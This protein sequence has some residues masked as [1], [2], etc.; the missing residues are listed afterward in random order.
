MMTPVRT[1]ACLRYAILL[2]LI[3]GAACD[4]P[5]EPKTRNSGFDI[6]VR[7]FEPLTP[8]QTAAFQ[9]AAARWQSVITGDLPDVNITTGTGVTA[10]RCN[11]RHPAF[12]GLIDDLLIFVDVDSIDG[13]NAQVGAGGPCF[14]RNGSRL[15][16]IGVMK[17]DRADMQIMQANGTLQNVILHEMGHVLGFSPDAW[18]ELGLVADPDSDDPIFTGANARNRFVLAGGTSPSGVPLENT[19]GAGTRGAHW[20]ETVFGAELMTGFISTG[21]TPLSAITLGSL[22]DIGYEVDYGAADTYSIPGMAALRVDEP[23]MRINEQIIRPIG[24]IAP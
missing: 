1:R 22:A 16:V 13:P 18:S 15:T 12:T 8:L 9:A 17:F 24:G 23:A 3:A 10:N 14:F 2:V 21:L 20:R 5:S 11:I 19:G 4:S 6:E 7:Y